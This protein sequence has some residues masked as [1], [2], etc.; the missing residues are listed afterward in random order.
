MSIE[1]RTEPNTIQSTNQNRATAA[2]SLD[3]LSVASNVTASS[4]YFGARVIVVVLL[5]IEAAAF[6]AAIFG[7]EEDVEVGALDFVGGRLVDEPFGADVGKLEE[8]AGMD[9]AEVDG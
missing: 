7:T 3:V 9:R 4:Q 2:G 8:G 1:V 5:G 6:F